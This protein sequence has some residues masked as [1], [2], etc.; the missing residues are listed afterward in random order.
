MSLSVSAIAILIK[1]LLGAKKCYHGP[2]YATPLDAMKNGPREKLLYIQCPSLSKDK[3]DFLATVDVDPK[4]PCYGKV[5][6]VSSGGVLSR[7]PVD[8]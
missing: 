5:F 3:P 8:A 1:C 4:S 7:D 6:S 2:G